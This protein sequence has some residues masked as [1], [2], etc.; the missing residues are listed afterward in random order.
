MKNILVISTSLRRNSNSEA[1]ADEFIKGA[2]ESGNKVEK[3]TLRDKNIAFCK[4]CLA[5]QSLHRCVIKDDSQEIVEKMLKAD[6]IVWATPVYYYCMSGQMKTMIDRANPLFAMDYAF[7]D[8]YLLA[9]AA[10]DE[11]SAVKGTIEGLKGWIECFERAEFAGYV[12]AGGVNG[13]GEVK[14]HKALKE[15]YKTGK[16]I[17]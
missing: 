9:S 14:G 6:V 8:V 13:E 15:A 10:E 5:C 3:A 7:R 17:N 2:K 12:F 16:S 1:L 4:G 11:E